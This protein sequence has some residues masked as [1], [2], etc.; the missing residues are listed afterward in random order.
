MSSKLPYARDRLVEV[1]FWVVGIYFE[2]RYS[3]ARRMLTKVNKLNSIIDDT[4]DANYATF[5]ELVLFTDAI[6]RYTL[7][8]CSPSLILLRLARKKMLLL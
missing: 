3:R 5:D 4:F 1:H 7:Y 2:P 8:I 6:Q